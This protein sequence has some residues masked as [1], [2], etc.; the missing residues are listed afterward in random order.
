[1]YQTNHQKKLLDFFKEHHNKSYSVKN[2]IEL[3]SSEMN[4]ATI[5]RRL[6]DLEK[7][8]ILRKS[9]NPLNRSYEYQYSSNCNQHLHLCCK[10][11]GNIT[12]LS[13]ERTL[14]FVNQL[15]DEHSFIVDQGSSI[16]YGIC[17]ECSKRA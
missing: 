14:G 6:E 12:H 9:Y 5:Y 4:R 2:L 1:M 7:N 16:L 8:Q 17:K 10:V 15:N 11:C 13:G 3:F